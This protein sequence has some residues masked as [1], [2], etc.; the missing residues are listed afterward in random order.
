MNKFYFFAII[1]I[2]AMFSLTSC[3][4]DDEGDVTKPVINLIEPEDG[5]TLTIGDENGVHFEMEVS[6]DTALGSYKIDIHNNF[7]G[8]NHATR[9][10]DGSTTPF[11]FNKTYNDI[12]GQRNA[13]VHHHDIVIP[14]NATPGKYHLM[15]YLVDQA[16]NESYAAREIV[17]E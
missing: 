4:S 16:G 14:A 1:A 17:L 5:A 11:V 8:H 2:A 12:S 6:D 7:D 3:S 10:S 9:A 15:V 13:T